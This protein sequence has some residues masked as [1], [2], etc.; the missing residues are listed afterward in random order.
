IDPRPIHV[1]NLRVEI[2]QLRMYRRVAGTHGI[3]P[4]RVHAQPPAKFSGNIVMFEIDDHG[5]LQLPSKTKVKRPVTTLNHGT[6]G[7]SYRVKMHHIRQT[8]VTLVEKT[9][10]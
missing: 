5:N 4:R 8:S 10:L 2:E 9:A 7:C 6:E 3:F 1:G